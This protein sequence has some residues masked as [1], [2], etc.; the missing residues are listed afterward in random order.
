[1]SYETRNSRRQNRTPALVMLTAITVAT[2]TTAAWSLINPTLQPH[3]LAKQ[4]KAVI[5]TTIAGRDMDAGTMTLKV[6]SVLKGQFESKHITVTTTDDT[7]DEPI[8]L[9]D[10]QKIV[11][12]VSKTQGRGL[13]HNVRFYTGGG[14]W[15]RAALVDGKMDH[16]Q[17]VEVLDGQEVDSMFGVYNGDPGQ[18][19]D[20][21]A[22][23]AQGR[24]YFP[25][26]PYQQFSQQT[27]GT[28]DQPLRGVALHD[29]DGD[30][31]LDAYATSAAGNRLFLQDGPMKFTD[32]TARAGLDGIAGGSCSFADVNVDGR[33]DLLADGAL[34]LQQDDGTFAHTNRLPEAANTDVKS[35]AFVDLNADGYPD[36]VVS[37]VG[38]GLHAYANPGTEGGPFEQVTAAM[39]LDQAGADGTGF[40][41]P[42]DWNDDGRIDLYYGAQSGF[43]MVQND[44]GVFQAM[45]LGVNLSTYEDQPGL[46][47]AG[48]MA[49]LWTEGD[50]SLI[51]PSDASYTLIVQN[52]GR[53]SNAI[54]STNELEN[55]PAENQIS[56][57]CE[58]LDADGYV[59][60]FTGTR[61]G[62]CNYHA[63]RGYGSYMRSAKY[64]P[65]AF[66]E[67]FHTG[68]WGLAAGDV[69]GDGANDLLLGGVDG[70]LTLMVNRCLEKRA[71]DD[72]Q[73][74]DYHEL[75][76]ANTQIVAV[77]VR[78]PLGVTGARLF[79]KN[80]AGQT[81]ARRDIGSNVNVGSASSSA[82]NIAVREPGNYELIVTWSDGLRRTM[83][84]K[85]DG[86]QHLVKLTAER[87]D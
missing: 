24:Y 6:D 4:Y 36:V 63:N 32:A 65:S 19:A 20:M 37:K 10:G 62:P 34:Y 55:E 87:G 25:P 41:A 28:F 60:I 54:T 46:T 16:W 73:A 21:M 3:G 83:A 15:Q 1:M 12:Y 76:R 82:A 68:A 5:G 29:V 9:D 27:L 13:K 70:S 84:V 40:F 78:G 14:V 38:G 18:F 39:G 71:T 17:W 51:I 79:L 69:N 30:G 59:D 66:P 42:G 72:T 53:M 50:L 85:L 45:S 11:A 33:A 47:G 81:V 35:A 77:D 56:V 48:A 61:Q 44:Q 43:L 80:E 58:D 26:R 8:F 67:A 86:G 31:D 57:L 22:D 2:L 7:K 23:F 74:L 75:K 52:E 64:D 49:P